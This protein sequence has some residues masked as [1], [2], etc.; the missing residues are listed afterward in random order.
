MGRH[1][2]R[3]RYGWGTIG[4]ALARAGKRVLFC[5]KGKSFLTGKSALRGDYAEHYLESPEHSRLVKQ[6]IMS[7][8]GRWHEEIED[9]SGPRHRSFV[10]FIGLGAGGSSALYGM[11][12]ERFFP[13]DF[14]PCATIR[15]QRGRASL[16]SGR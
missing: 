6:E 7:L 3:D 1:R 5:E 16:S 14:T 8:A 12:L 15:R 4:Y 10:P 2:H 11:A 9:V 13:S